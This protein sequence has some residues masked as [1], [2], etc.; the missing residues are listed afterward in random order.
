MPKTI[1]NYLIVGLKGLVLVD[2]IGIIEDAFPG[3]GAITVQTA[4]EAA[5]LVT[6][7]KSVRFAFLNV[8]PDDFIQTEL[9]GILSDLGTRIVLMGKAAEE[10]AG[11]LPYDVLDRPFAGPDVIR[12]L[13]KER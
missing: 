5:E 3:L 7:L 12:I 4:Q 10:K 11:A 9:A 1:Q 6:T 2:V 8:D 13:K